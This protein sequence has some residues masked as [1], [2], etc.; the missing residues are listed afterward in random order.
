MLRISDERRHR[1]LL[2]DSDDL[3]GNDDIDPIP[4][5]EGSTTSTAH[6]GSGISVWWVRTSPAI[7]ALGRAHDDW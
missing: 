2:H 7:L 3:V 6:P 4:V 5:G 1:Q